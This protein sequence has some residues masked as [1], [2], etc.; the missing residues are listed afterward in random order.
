[1]IFLSS[2]Q[3]KFLLTFC[4]HFKKLE[5]NLIKSIWLY[6][7]I[8][9]QS[10]SL[11]E[12]ILWND[13]DGIKDTP[14]PPLP[15]IVKKKKKKDSKLNINQGFTS[16]SSLQMFNGTFSYLHYVCRWE[17]EPWGA[18]TVSCGAGS[19]TREVYC[20]QKISTSMTVRLSDDMCD[21]SRLAS[22]QA[23]NAHRCPYWKP[24]PW[25]PVS[26]PAQSLFLQKL[27]SHT[28]PLEF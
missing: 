24:E 4:F 8:F 22:V 7:Y 2:I 10:I 12:G 11:A 5:W 27:C 16:S 25:S 23:C 18:C 19:Q 14:P 13:I 15:T 1:M 28:E 17:G 6:L 21:G 3:M 20:V 26:R 9:Y